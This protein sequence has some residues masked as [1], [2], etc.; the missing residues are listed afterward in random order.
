MGTPESS[1][2][3]LKFDSKDLA[4]G[5]RAIILIHEWES[6]HFSRVF[7]HLKRGR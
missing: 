4:Q 1:R 5:L 2:R 3:S 6:G 7:L